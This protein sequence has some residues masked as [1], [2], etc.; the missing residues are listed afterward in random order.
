MVAVCT[1]TA[2]VGCADI[3]QPGTIPAPSTGPNRQAT[4]ITDDGQELPYF[5]NESQVPQNYTAYVKSVRAR[6]QWNDRIAEGY[7]SSEWYGNRGVMKLT[8]SILYGT[9]HVASPS[10]EFHQAT[11]FPQ[12]QIKGQPFQYTV[13][14]TCDHTANFFVKQSART[15]YWAADMGSVSQSATDGAARADAIQPSCPKEEDEN[16]PPP[17]EGGSGPS[18]GGGGSGGGGSAPSGGGSWCQTTTYRVEVWNGS[19]WVFEKYEYETTCY[20]N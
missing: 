3:T 11:L 6:V 18:D 7:G 15:T 14:S 5:E 9:T 12:D 17:G 20:S 19:E 16:A 13:G 1:A 4:I 8:L 10:E 2:A